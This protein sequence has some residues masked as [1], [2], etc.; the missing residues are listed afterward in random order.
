MTANLIVWSL[1]ALAL[2]ALAVVLAGGSQ[3]ALGI[4]VACA[5]LASGIA[6]AERGDS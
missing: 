5:I 4:G 6:D 1:T 3:A 2:V